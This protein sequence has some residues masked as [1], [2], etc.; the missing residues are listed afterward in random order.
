MN[1]DTQTNTA[2]S[3]AEPSQSTS[4]H[5]DPSRRRHSI[6]ELAQGTPLPP[7]QIRMLSAGSK[8]KMSK[9][10]NAFAP[11]DEEPSSSHAAYPGLPSGSNGEMD[12]P[13]PKRRG[14]TA[15]TQRIGQLSL[16]DRR[17]S[18]DS[19]GPN[20]SPW[21]TGPGDRGS[22]ST[23][24]PNPSYGSPTFAG[25]PSQ[26]RPPAGMPG[27]SWSNSEPHST[28]P[29][30]TPTN[31]LT[32]AASP[33]DARVDPSLS[34]LSNISFD[35][36][37]RMSITGGS[38]PPSGSGGPSRPTGRSDSSAPPIH[39]TEGD[40]GMAPPP[41]GH[42]A[43]PPGD[44]NAETSSS[45]S[46]GLKPPG[47]SRD[48]SSQPYSR[49]PELRVSHKLAE[50]KRRKEMK[51][52]FDELR[53]HLPA[54]R[55][56]KSSKWEIL[57]KGESSNCSASRHHMLTRNSHRLCWS[58]QGKS[59]PDG[60]RNQYSPQR[61]GGRTIRR[62]VRGARCSPYGLQRSDNCSRFRGSLCSRRFDSP[63]GPRWPLAKHIPTPRWPCIRA[64]RSG[65]I[66]AGPTDVCIPSSGSTAS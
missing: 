41:L 34:M 22:P 33:G 49:S 42:G 51:E 25:S 50:R 55:G 6:Q 58:S 54:D 28:D 60:T 10:A 27:F 66:F 18:V 40:A 47:G 3:Q 65:I 62:A 9:D 64:G 53:D 26:S 36:N 15:D 11:V 59:S 21:W 2:Y 4:S 38:A 52:L 56:M 43:A 31:T 5:F 24:F 44:L 12:G 13:A 48:G 45:G 17:H 8:R 19:R 46:T 30:S 57:S 37:R 20:E 63:R 23:A 39:E 61:I 32:T 7:G 16:Y 14:S 35:T 1:V 29:A